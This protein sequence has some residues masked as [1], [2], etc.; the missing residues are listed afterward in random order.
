MNSWLLP[1]IVASL[2]GSV[3]LTLSYAYLAWISKDRAMHLWTASWFFYSL[4]FVFMLAIIQ[5]A[6]SKLLLILNQ[7]CLPASGLLLLWGAFSFINK[8][9][10]AVW[11]I[12]GG[13]ILL[14]V[15][16]GALLD[17]SFLHYT[18]PTFAFVGAANIRTGIIFLRFPTKNTVLTYTPAIALILWGLHK[19]NYP[20]LRPLECFAPWGYLLGSVLA[21]FLAIAILVMHFESI[22]ARLKQSEDAFRWTFDKAAVGIAHVSP[23]GRYLRVNTT[24]CKILGYS[25]EE[26]YGKKFQ[27]ITHPDD[28]QKSLDQ[29]TRAFT[30]DLDNFDFEKRYLRKDGS[31]VW[32]NVT[33]SIVRDAHG[34]P[35]YFI[36]VVDDI[37]TRKH[38]EEKIKDLARFP[39]ENPNPVMRLSR[40]GELLYANEASAP[41]LKAYNL[42]LNEIIHPGHPA[43]RLFEAVG[44]YREFEI[45]AGTKFYAI[46]SS[47]SHT[48]RLINLYGMDVT[49]H[50]H[51]ERA[52]KDSEKRFRTL[53][54]QSLHGIC[55]FEDMPPRFALANPA[56][57]NIVGRSL[58]EIMEMAPG[59]VWTLVHPEDR[60]KVRQR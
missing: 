47:F 41:I 23:E 24:M 46:T 27:S 39:N 25:S 14:W 17:F 40:D 54:E 19:L 4:R 18:L 21:F 43:E 59:Q 9:I 50:K 5:S 57:C 10:S 53:F 22:T 44:S 13:F 7:A 11:T 32:T 1:S 8:R 20:F 3:I 6:P 51:A 38:A 16:A 30:D 36:S 37:T 26:L 15:F 34:I 58:K 49:D 52:L 42:S 56:F 33:V 60:S 55:I 2:S 28:L 12:T 48:S 45:Q 29:M 35:D 31:T